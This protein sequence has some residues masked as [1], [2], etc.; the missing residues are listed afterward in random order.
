MSL[1]LTLSRPSNQLSFAEE[2]VTGR[3]TSGKIDVDPCWQRSQI[4]L[5]DKAAR[6][7]IMLTQRPQAAKPDNGMKS[8]VDSKTGL[9]S[10]VT[11][12]TPD[13][14]NGDAKRIGVKHNEQKSSR[15]ENRFTIDVAACTAYLC[16]VLAVT[17]P[18]LLVPLAIEEQAAGAAAGSIT[19]PVGF[20]ASKVATV[21]SVASVGGAL[22]MFLN[23]FV[24]KEL[25]TY[26]CSK[27]YLVG[28]ALCTLCFS[29]SPNDLAIGVSYAGMEFFSSIQYASFAIMLSDFH[30]GK[31]EKTATALTA[32]GLSATIGEV[33]SKV[34]ATSLSSAMHWR[35]VAMLGSVIAFFGA[36]V[37]SK[38]PGQTEAKRRLATKGPFRLSS[39]TNSLNAILGDVL[40]WK[41]AL[42]YSMTFVASISDRVIGPFFHSVTTLPLGICGG[43]TLSITLGLIHGLI[44]ASKKTAKLQGPKEWERFLRKRYITSIA[45]SFGLTTLA[46]LGLDRISNPHVMAALLV[47]LSGTMS[48]NIAYQFYQMPVLIADR[49]AGHDAVC[50]SFLDGFGFLFSAP[51]FASLGVI[52]PEFGW[53]VGWGMLS[54]LFAIAGLVMMKSIVPILNMKSDDKQS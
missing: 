2:Q 9:Q 40:F 51:L 37:I 3:N 10:V 41:I 5:L 7:P 52:V 23:G 8:Q 20:V 47:G 13:D 6:T 1:T 29:V 14:S 22:G 39:I 53:P 33:L 19:D 12:T 16:D 27:W 49:Y 44:T 43:L 34:L 48:S 50:I 32:L 4:C 30:K 21:S 24:C 45:A 15:L 11:A 28:L 25:G 42:A 18:I 17:L 35:Q 54:S 46:Y 31:P 38:A 26:A 36:A